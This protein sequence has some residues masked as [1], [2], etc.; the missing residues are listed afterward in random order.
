M[1]FAVLQF[2]NIKKAVSAMRNGSFDEN[3]EGVF[4]KQLNANSTSNLTRKPHQ[5]STKPPK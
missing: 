1:R 2:L 5:Q 4:S 3:T